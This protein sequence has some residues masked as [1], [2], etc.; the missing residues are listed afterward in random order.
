MEC[1]LTQKFPDAEYCKFLV[2]QKA[3]QPGQTRPNPDC[4]TKKEW[5]QYKIYEDEFTVTTGISQ[6]WE[7]E[8]K[9]HMLA[10]NEEQAGVVADMM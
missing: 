6:E 9:T 4:P 8:L 2:K 1:Q 5:K 3:K 10:D 7:M